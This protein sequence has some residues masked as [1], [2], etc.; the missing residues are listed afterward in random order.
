[1]PSKQHQEM[2][3]AKVSGA[4][5]RRAGQGPGMWPLTTGMIAL[6]ILAGSVQFAP[7]R[8]SAASAPSKSDGVVRIATPLGT[9]AEPVFFDV[10][11]SHVPT[12]QDAWD[13]AIYGTLLRTTPN[14]GY[15]PELAT[16]ATIVDPQTIDIQ[17]RKGVVFSDGEPFTANAVR[18]GLLHNR[19]AKQLGGF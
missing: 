19:N 7:G 5:G 11:L 16:R 13:M 3:H 2:R 6:A 10:T 17:L 12:V 18:A 14:G 1:M 8:A 15:V 9:G 4:P